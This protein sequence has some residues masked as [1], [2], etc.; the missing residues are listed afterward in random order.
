[1]TAYDTFG[2]AYKSCLEKLLEEGTRV[3]GTCDPRSP[4][5]RFGTTVRDTKE[6]TGFSFEIKD[7]SQC[8][9]I[10]KARPL[11][12]AYC[13]GSLAWT[14]NG[15]D[16]L[17]EIAFY[18]PR[19]RDFSDDG[20]H[21]SGAFGKRL[22]KYGNKLDQVDLIARKLKQDP[23]SRRT[24]A[25]I[26]LPS[27][28]AQESREYP[29]AI[30]VQYLMRGDRLHAITF[31]RSQ[32]AALVLPYDSFLFMSVQ[33]IIAQ[34]L[35]VSPGPY[36]HLSGSFHYY[37]DESEIVQRVSQEDNIT[38]SFGDFLGEG[39]DAHTICD[40][41]KR[42]RL[43]CKSAQLDA[44]EALT[45][46][47]A[48]QSPAPPEPWKIVL[49]AHAFDKLNQPERALELSGKLTDPVRGLLTQNLERGDA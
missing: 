45:K 15:S 9:L 49:L 46:T 3:P 26:L 24:V 20:V 23:S 39:V 47:G 40:F 7:G 17:E 30:A 4:G 16:E 2:E 21:L 10:S 11:R 38:I 27:D 35:G 48:G 28:Q 32:S 13:V 5:S 6:L 31:M 41:E 34:R 18:N 44:L 19:G 36:T 25:A 43:A 1:M 29:C 42:V 14:L 8:L 33:C 37:S 12:L 22:F